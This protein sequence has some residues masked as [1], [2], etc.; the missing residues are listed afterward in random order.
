MNDDDDDD[1]DNTLHGASFVATRLYC[2]LFRSQDIV[3]GNPKLLD[4]Y[5]HD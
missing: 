1:D 2:L 4:T 5:G 3:S